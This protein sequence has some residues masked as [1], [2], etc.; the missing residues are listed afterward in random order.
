MTNKNILIADIGGTNARFAFASNG[1][2]GFDRAQTL[3]CSDYET[4]EAAIDAY[5][6]DQNESAVEA[7]C[8]AAAGPVINQRIKF[9]NN[10]WVIEVKSLRERYST[11]Q[12]FLLNDWVSIAYGL[13]ELDDSHS[14]PI[15]DASGRTWQLPHGESYSIGGI[16]PGSG[17]GV[18]GLLRRNNQFV[19]IVTE[20]GHTGFAPQTHLQTEILLILQRKFE[21]VSNERILSGPGMVNLYQALC[22]IEGVQPRELNASQIG[23]ESGSDKTCGTSLCVFF[24]VLGQVAGDLVLT[25]GTYDGIFIGGGICQQ[26]PEALGESNFR[27]GFK[28]KGRHQHVLEEVPTWLITHKNPGLLGAAAYAKS[29]LVEQLL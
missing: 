13:P 7:I 1:E 22:E 21:R 16:G 23:A 9:T 24:E 25:L 11:E 26:Y 15:G 12:V 18:T 29:Q 4:V 10:A 27:K 3:K 17:L 20:G 28:N 6:A 5:L 8:F 19:P 2:E 14:S